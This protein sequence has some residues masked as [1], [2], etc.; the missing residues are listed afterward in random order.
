LEF[1]NYSR[2]RKNILGCLDADCIVSQNYIEEIINNFNKKSISAAHVNFAHPVSGND[3]EKAAIICYEIFLRHYVWSLKLVGSPYGFFS[4]GSTMFCDSES[5]IKVQGMNKRKA[6]EDFYFMEKLAKI[7]KIETIPNALVFPS[8][9]GSRRVPFGTGQ[10]V[11]RFLEGTH[12]EH[13]LYSPK[14]FS[15]LKEWLEFFMGEQTLPAKEYLAE[16]KKINEGLFKFFEINFFER[17]WNKILSGSQSIKQI[18]K[19]KIIWFDGFRTLKLIHYLRDNAFPNE[20]MFSVLDEMF[21]QENLGIITPQINDILPPIETR[22]KYLEYL[23][24]LT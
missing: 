8:G 17:N 5:Y 2:R 1:F 21:Y 18:N 14:S 3:N 22:L 24:K 9:R 11:N 16:A 6:A 10:R 19:Q 20:P 23:R 7:T 4:I 12:E 15:V 13:T